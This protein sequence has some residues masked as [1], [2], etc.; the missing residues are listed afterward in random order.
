[1]VRNTM[2]LS[3]LHRFYFGSKFTVVVTDLDMVKEVCVKQFDRFV[4][5]GSFAVS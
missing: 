4:D 1:M 2:Y 3:P 5:R